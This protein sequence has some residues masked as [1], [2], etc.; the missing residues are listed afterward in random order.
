MGKQ[1]LV[2]YL[3]HDD[4]PLVIK[5]E[6]KHLGNTVENK[7][8]FIVKATIVDI[9]DNGRWHEE[10]VL[11]DDEDTAVEMFEAMCENEGMEIVGNMDARETDIDIMVDAE[12]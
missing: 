5:D 1:Y 8:A 3:M 9:D 2:R 6:D 12:S 7:D 4:E 10:L 11:S